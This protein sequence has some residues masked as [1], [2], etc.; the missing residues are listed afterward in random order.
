MLK[1]SLPD[2]IY[3]CIHVTG[4]TTIPN[5]TVAGASANDNKKLILRNFAPFK[6]CISKTNNTQVGHAKDTNVVILMDNLIEYS[7]IY[8][9]T[10]QSLWQYYREE[11]FLY[12]SGNIADS[13]A[14]NNGISL[15]FKE[16]IKCKQENC[17]LSISLHNISFDKRKGVHYKTF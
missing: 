11:P 12:G 4:T 10:S 16:K 8:S 7:N 17:H 3:A 9:K 2:Y 15:K 14:I 6:K 1:L 13:P 5:T